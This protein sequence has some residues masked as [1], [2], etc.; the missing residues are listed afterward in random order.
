MQRFDFPTV[1]D[2]PLSQEVE[3]LGVGGLATEEAEVARGVHEAGAEM[4]M[5]QAVSEHAGGD[6]VVLGDPIRQRDAAFT[7]R[8][9][10]LQFIFGGDLVEHAEAG[11]KHLGQ[12]FHRVATFLDES[13]GGLGLMCADP[14][15]AEFRH[16][17]D[18]LVEDG[19]LASQ[20]RQLLGFFGGGDFAA[21]AFEGVRG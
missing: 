14:H 7:F 17:G 20:F 3:E 16:G 5:P 4:V 11:G 19:E 6:G 21:D 8:G 12:G 1:G 15:L 9:V 10:G 13:R 2:Q 18:A